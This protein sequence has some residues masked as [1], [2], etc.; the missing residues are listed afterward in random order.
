MINIL[1]NLG[2]HKSELGGALIKF[3]SQVV[4]CRDLIIQNTMMKSQVLCNYPQSL[5]CIRA[6]EQISISI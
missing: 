4:K 5:T 2:C 3:N 6:G 1:K